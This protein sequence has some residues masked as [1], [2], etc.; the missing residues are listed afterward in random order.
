MMIKAIKYIFESGTLVASALP[1][2][3]PER[4]HYLEKRISKF[5]LICAA[6]VLAL[7]I[8]D[9]VI[10]SRETAILTDKITASNKT[11]S[12]LADRV[13]ASNKETAILTQRVTVAEKEAKPVPL[14][15]RLRKVLEE[16][17]PKIIPALK[18]GQ[19]GF[20]GGITASQFT[21]FQTIA[22]EKGARDFIGV[23]PASVRVGIGM[24]PEGVTYRVAFKPAPKL[25]Q[26]P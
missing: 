19:T 3:A 5:C 24:G 13:A 8:T 26:Q 23:D 1:V 4:F 16:I 14:A 17:D 12:T 15:I 20:E 7:S 2:I 6:A 21:R 9:D 18:S 25:L 11:I 22:N 10:S